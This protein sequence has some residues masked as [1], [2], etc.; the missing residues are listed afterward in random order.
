MTHRHVRTDEFGEPVRER[1]GDQSKRARIESFLEDNW[2]T[3]IT[4]AMVACG[5]YAANVYRPIQA[6]PAIIARDSVRAAQHEDIERKIEGMERAVLVLS[7]INCFALDAA[8]RVKYDIDCRTIP[9]PD[10]PPQRR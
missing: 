1:A 7:R 3:I 2:R 5:W 4:F 10:N 9:L 6:I 8:D